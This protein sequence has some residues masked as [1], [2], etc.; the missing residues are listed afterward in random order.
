MAGFWQGLW[1]GLIVPITFIISLF[2]KS[3]HMYEVHNNG[4]W[5]NCGFLLGAC[6]SLG[7]GARGAARRSPPKG[8]EPPRTVRLEISTGEPP[9]I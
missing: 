4:A 7:G 8:D 1:H 3:V 2:S 9:A 5:Y 6:I